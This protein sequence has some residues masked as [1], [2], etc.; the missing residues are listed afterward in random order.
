MLK[1][2]F[3]SHGHFASGIKSTLNILVGNT[4]NLTVFDAYVDEQSVQ[5][6][7]TQYYQQEV[8]S[9]DQVILLSDVYGGSVNQAML[10]YSQRS[11]TT[12]ITGVNLP[13]L[14]E[15]VMKESLTEEEIDQIIESSRAMIKVVKV[16]DLGDMKEKE[17]DF[18]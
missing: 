16:E 11:D 9:G 13:L 12:L 14:M 5:E 3:S 4:N 1:L 15:L 7:L 2:F 8:H 10:P 17:E 6:V 18:F